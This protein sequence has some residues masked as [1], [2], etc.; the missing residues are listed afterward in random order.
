MLPSLSVV[1]PCACNKQSWQFI[2]SIIR[3]SPTESEIKV[4]NCECK[5]TNK[6]PKEAIPFQFD[7]HNKSKMTSPISSHYNS[8]A[9]KGRGIVLHLSGTDRQP[10]VFALGL[11]FLMKQA[12][13][14]ELFIQSTREEAS[15]LHTVIT[16]T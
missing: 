13:L 8:G 11:S 10:Q 5:Q 15:L 1:Q 3:C 4:Y 12:E 6:P 7:A 14:N 9:K 16:Q 2:R